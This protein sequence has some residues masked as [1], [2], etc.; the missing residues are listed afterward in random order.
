MPDWASGRRNGWPRRFRSRRA[1]WP[2]LLLLPGGLGLYGALPEQPFEP[3]AGPLVG[4]V[5]R[6]A[7][8]DTIEI[9]GQRVRL[10]GLDAPEWDQDCRRA[11][12][13]AWS[14]G[15]A[16]TDRMREL[17]RGRELSCTASGRDRYGRLL[18]TCRAGGLDVAETLV[19]EGLAV[20]SGRYLAAEAAARRAAAGL[21]QGSFDRPTDW[22]SGAGRTGAEA[23]GNPS[24][25]E[26]V[27]AWLWGLF[28]S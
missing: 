27:L 28:V 11:D 8:G 20:A 19:G 26:R 24:R 5:E 2:W 12:G 4:T 17:T 13:S 3:G 23:P 25:L 18:A 21:W 6:V 15:R 10:A 22:R 16:A 14:C 9:A 7:D 1:A